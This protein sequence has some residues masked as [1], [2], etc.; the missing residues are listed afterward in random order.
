MRFIS[1]EL[2]LILILI[3]ISITSFIMYEKDYVVEGLKYIINPT[4]DFIS[5]K[6]ITNRVKQSLLYLLKNAVIYF[7]YYGYVLSK[8]WNYCKVML[9]I[10][11]IIFV[12]LII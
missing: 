11:F 2:F 9:I 10:G 1:K 8:L 7:G 12:S 4:F 3:S 5:R 6:F